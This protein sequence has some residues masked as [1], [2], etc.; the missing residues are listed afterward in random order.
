MKIIIVMAEIENKFKV[1]DVV[2]H[3]TTNKFKML[4]VD[5]CYPKNPTIEQEFHNYKDLSIYKC[6]YYNELTNN[7]DEECFQ[8]A[9]LKLFTE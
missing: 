4:I 7:W 1:G 5:N 8:E 9:E 2:V 6:R 3:K